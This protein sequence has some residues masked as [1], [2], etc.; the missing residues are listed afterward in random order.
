MA[1]P[2][3]DPLGSWKPLH[4]ALSVTIMLVSGTRLHAH[5]SGLCRNKHAQ[6]SGLVCTPLWLR[7]TLVKLEWTAEASWMSE[8]SLRAAGTRRR[9][10]A[11]ILSAQQPSEHFQ[12]GADMIKALFEVG[13]SVDRHRAQRDTGNSQQDTL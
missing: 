10:S 4:P 8:G 2:A 7:V 3:E 5:G 12:W 1:G 9:H 6:T 13:H 11:F